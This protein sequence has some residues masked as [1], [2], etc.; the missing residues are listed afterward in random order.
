MSFLTKTLVDEHR[1]FICIPGIFCLIF[2]DFFKIHLKCI[3]I[4][5]AFAPMSQNTM[6]DDTIISLEHDLEKALNMK[7]VLC[8][9]EQHDQFSQKRN[10]L[11]WRS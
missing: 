4:I 1:M 3:F 5:G 2:F 11:F 10:L 6:S 8:I 9:F 7:L